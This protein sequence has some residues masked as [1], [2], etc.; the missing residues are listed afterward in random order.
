MTRSGLATSKTEL[1]DCIDDIQH[2]LVRECLRKTGITKRVEIATMGDVP[3]EGSGLGS[4]ST[5]TVGLLNAM[6]SY[7]GVHQDAVTLAREACEIEID[8]LKQP[9]GVQDQY[10]AAIGGQRLMRFGADGYVRFDDLQLDP[11]HWETLNR[12]LMLFFTNTTRKAETVLSQQVRNIPVKN[13]ALNEM[14]QLVHDARDCLA[15]GCFDDFGHLLDT[16]WRL[17]RQ[18]AKNISNSWIE[19]LYNSARAAGAIGGKIVGAG[20]G[21]YLL[22]YCR[23]ERQPDVRAALKGLPELPFQFEPFGT[24]IIFNYGSGLRKLPVVQRPRI[25]AFRD[26]GVQNAISA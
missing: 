22:L 10:I 26:S 1:V 20:G 2:D 8:V 6:Y 23:P 7:L 19:N 11:G 12:N 3:S 5:V 4:S 9:I 16:G 13:K 14:K 17:K 21:G 18:L 24:K 25:S 15:T